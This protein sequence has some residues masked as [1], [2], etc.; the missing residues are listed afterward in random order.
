VPIPGLDARRG[1]RPAHRRGGH[2]LLRA[3]IGDI[4]EGDV[5]VVFGAGPVGLYAAKSAW[6]MGAGG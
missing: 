3:S 6:L 2:R 1:R 4:V 5:V